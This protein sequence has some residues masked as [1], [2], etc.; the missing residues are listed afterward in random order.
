MMW[1]FPVFNKGYVKLFVSEWYK[2]WKG[3]LGHIDLGYIM[4]RDITLLGSWQD[5]PIQNSH[6]EHLY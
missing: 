3:L 5:Q 6:K 2:W 4:Y 1:N